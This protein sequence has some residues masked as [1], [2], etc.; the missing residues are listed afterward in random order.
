MNSDGDPQTAL[1]ETF[2]AVHMQTPL[3]E[4]IRRGRQLRT[5]RRRMAGITGV[6]CAAA[7]AG[8]VL[9]VGLA[10]GGARPDNVGRGNGDQLTAYSVTKGPHDTVV[11]RVWQLG[12]PAGLQRMLRADGVPAHVA[13]QGGTLSDDPPI[14]RSCQNVNMSD[15]AN[16]QLQGKIIGPPSTRPGPFHG[17]QGVTL[18]LNV[19]AI[20]K[21][22]GINLT[23]QLYS[24][25]WGWSLGLV[26][27]TPQCTGS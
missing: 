25:S 13:F 24:H 11:V 1:R 23:V 12:D 6:A 3:D 5:R 15:E 4:T 18:T 21:K 19:A 27:R 20:P 22:I 10:P 9:A 2:A 8:G 7:V 26:Q 16:A 17:L 14:P